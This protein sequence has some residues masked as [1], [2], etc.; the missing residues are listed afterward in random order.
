MNINYAH[1]EDYMY[2]IDIIDDLKNYLKDLDSS[3]V[4]MD[5]KYKYIN[6]IYNL[7]D[8]II[9]LLFERNVTRYNSV[10]NMNIK[11]R[12]NDICKDL[13]TLTNINLSTI[14]KNVIVEHLDCLLT[15]I[16]C[17]LYYH[18]LN[19]IN[20]FNKEINVCEECEK[21]NKLIRNQYK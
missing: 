21:N 17:L 2:V 12:I 6:K 14:N 20:D 5:D 13:T 4:G 16:V 19:T 8:Y 18:T 15:D 9:D 10:I 1:S 11:N 7:T 3:N